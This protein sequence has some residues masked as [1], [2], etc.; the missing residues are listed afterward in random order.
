MSAYSQRSFHNIPI[1]QSTHY[2]IKLHWGD[3]FEKAMDIKRDVIDDYETQLYYNQSTEPTTKS[4]QSSK[5][6]R[7][8]ITYCSSTAE[9]LVVTTLMMKPK[10][11]VAS[12]HVMSTVIPLCGRRILCPLTITASTRSSHVRTP[13]RHG[14]LKQMVKR[15]K[16]ITSLSSWSLI[17]YQRHIRSIF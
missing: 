17:Q 3:T 7:M 10:S 9:P 12:F 11:I 5:T 16:L 8:I 1:G 13:S 4:Y 2:N 6:H 15:S 14:S